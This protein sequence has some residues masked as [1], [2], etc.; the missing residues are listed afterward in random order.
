MPREAIQLNPDKVKLQIARSGIPIKQLLNGMTSKT[1]HRIKAG[2][3]TTWAT[4]HRLA[5][6]LGIK[7]EDMMG[8]VTTEEMDGFLPEQWLY[9]EA[10]A[11]D[12]IPHYVPFWIAIEG[13]GV[14][15]LVNRSPIDFK[16]PIEQLL[17]W[18]APRCRKIV[19]RK[20]DQ[21][22]VFEIHYF[23]YSP[24][25]KQ[26][27]VYEASTA[28]RFF[29]LARN[30]D[31]FAKIELTDMLHRYVWKRLK[32]LA[33]ENAEIV[34]IEGDNYPAHPYAYFPLVRFYQGSILK[35]VALGARI[36]EQ[37]Q[38]D[39]KWS[40]TGY[41]DGIDAGRVR[42]K[43]TWSGIALTVE[44]VRPVIYKLGWRE[45]VLEIEVDLVW[46]TPDGKLAL[47][48]W[49]QKHREEFVEAIAARKWNACY[50]RGMPTRYSPE[51]D[52][53]DPD[54]LPFAPDLSLS[55]DTIAAINA[56]DYPT[57]FGSLW[58]D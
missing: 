37:L 39:F 47:A 9:D 20:D 46:R 57:L 54:P 6:E 40:M 27:V 15:Y 50:S 16:S 25:R 34:S 48:P 2:K 55:A 56:M 43:T 18:H 1:V 14:R 38:A 26:E 12:G 36:F 45:E 53:E 33:L 51:N 31:T 49:R 29:P 24:D 10:P 8:S 11:P 23:E 35:R 44:P 58:D 30:G 19:L 21:A 32:R 4:A 5:T 7:V 13:G 28:C 52:E 3:N 22:F 17:E 42:A 41:L